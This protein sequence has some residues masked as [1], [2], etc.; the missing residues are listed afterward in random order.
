MRARRQSCGEDGHTG[1][2]GGT[3][4]G[5]AVFKSDCACRR[6]AARDWC[7]R[8][9]EGYRLAGAT[10]IRGGRQGYSC[11][12]LAR[13]ESIACANQDRHY[14]GETSEEVRWCFQFHALN[15]FVFH[16]VAIV[17]QAQKPTIGPTHSYRLGENY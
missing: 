12:D 3:A 8:S 17:A 6:T 14:Q 5:S 2:Q 11:V 16:D 1:H 10:W 7:H 13:G 15:Y 9:G 4:N